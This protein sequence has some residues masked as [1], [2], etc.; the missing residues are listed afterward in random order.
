[1]FFSSHFFN[2]CN[3]RIQPYLSSLLWWVGFCGFWFFSGHLLSSTPHP[4]PP[5]TPPGLLSFWKQVFVIYWK[6][7]FF[8]ILLA[9]QLNW[10]HRYISMSMYIQLFFFPLSSPVCLALLKSCNAVSTFSLDAVS[11]PS[12][13]STLP[14]SSQP[15]RVFPLALTAPAPFPQLCKEQGTAQWIP[16]SAGRQNALSHPP[17]LPLC[18]HPC[19]NIASPDVILRQDTTAPSQHGFIPSSYQPARYITD[20]GQLSRRDSRERKR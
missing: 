9:I 10:R 20:A 13:L 2:L 12:L 1:M 19:Q 7:S 18:L 17:S 14:L 8:R 11:A 5:P 3:D 6:Y 15:S 4:T 16:V